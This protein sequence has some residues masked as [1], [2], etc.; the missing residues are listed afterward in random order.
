ML[1][2]K[3]IQ[4]HQ[5]IAARLAAS[6]RGQTLAGT[7]LFYGPEGIGKFAAAKAFARAINCDEG[8]GSD[9]GA[10]SSCRRID[11]GSHPDVHI[12][13]EGY[14]TEIKIE[15][16]RLLQ[17]E[18]FLRPYEAKRKIFIINDSH[19]LNSVSANAL[20]KTLEETPGRSTIIL[21]TDKPGL[22]P[23]TIVSRCRRENFRCLGRAPFSA[24]LA[25]LG[26]PGE[27][28]EY[29]S[30]F[31]EG[32]IGLA[33]RL[34][35]SDVIA[36]KNRIID[37]FLSG[38]VDEAMKREDIRRELSVMMAWFRDVYVTKLG[39]ERVINSDRKRELAQGAARY[40]FGDLERIFY[41]IS[42]AYLYLDQNVNSKL[43]LA[44]LQVCLRGQ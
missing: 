32:R 14:E 33:V 10:C 20:L 15:S 31:C 19:N 6:V 9:C 29:L 40:G 1:T 13:D 41:G 38:N 17:E 12:I 30:F 44:N 22:M 34:R 8:N 3:D 16:V 26:Y 28:R 21:V 2:L 42:S 4:G 18:I 37:S 7:Y 36:E 35:G 27:A 43:L 24:A 23:S 25:S 39:L 11:A 5:D